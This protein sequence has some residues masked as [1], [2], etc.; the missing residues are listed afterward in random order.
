MVVAEEATEMGT[1]LDLREPGERG[2]N[3]GSQG[4]WPRGMWSRRAAG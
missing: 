1:S 3:E 2:Q 4:R